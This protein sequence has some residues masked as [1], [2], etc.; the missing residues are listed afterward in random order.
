MDV[1]DY[2]PVS[3]GQCFKIYLLCKHNLQG[4]PDKV[5]TMSLQPS[6]IAC[7]LRT[8][9]GGWNVENLF[10]L[11]HPTQWDFLCQVRSPSAFAILDRIGM[12]FFPVKSTTGPA[13]LQESEVGFDDWPFGQALRLLSLKSAYPMKH[14]HG[15]RC[16]VTILHYTCFHFVKPT[17]ALLTECTK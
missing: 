17:R 6:Q 15:E 1:S 9:D 14:L 11:P 16:F 10:F 3:L 7:D 5:H 13:A 8:F 12:Y 2:L 4:I